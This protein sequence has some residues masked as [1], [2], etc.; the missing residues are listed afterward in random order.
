MKNT[1]ETF[2]SQ[3]NNDESIHDA[4]TIDK[5]PLLDNDKVLNAFMKE[6]SG[7]KV[8]LLTPDNKIVEKKLN[9]YND[10]K[11]GV[12]VSTWGRFWNVLKDKEGELYLNSASNIGILLFDTCWIC[13]S[14][15]S[16]SVMPKFEY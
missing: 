4:T 15:I 11:E 12:K 1:L 9:S 2:Y 7:D 5:I 8:F 14:V 13:T 3:E 16:K 6:Q 10:L